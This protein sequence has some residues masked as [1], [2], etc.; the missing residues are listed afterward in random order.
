[1]QLPQQQNEIE[2]YRRTMLDDNEIISLRTQIKNAAEAKVENGTMTVS[3]LLQEIN[4]LE[5]ARQ[6]R[7]LHEIQY[8]MSIYTLKNI[9]N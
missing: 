1:M 9:T 3:D 5:I 7:S 2:K 4:A 6:A 8:L